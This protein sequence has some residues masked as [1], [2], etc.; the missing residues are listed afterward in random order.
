MGRPA[1]KH[2]SAAAERNIGSLAAKVYPEEGDG[3][4]VGGDA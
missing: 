2:G 4:L 3:G 1:A